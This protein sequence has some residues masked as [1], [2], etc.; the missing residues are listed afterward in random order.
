MLGWKSCQFGGDLTVT[1]C[2]NILILY[3]WTILLLDNHLRDR[4]TCM[5][6][7]ACRRMFIALLFVRM[8]NRKQPISPSVGNEYIN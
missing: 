7:E 8:K 3:E 5:Y 2:L 6:K 1:L 4:F